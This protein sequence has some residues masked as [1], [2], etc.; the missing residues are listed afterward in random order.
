MSLVDRLYIIMFISNWFVSWSFSFLICEIL[1]AV[2]CKKVQTRRCPFICNPQ[3]YLSRLLFILIVMNKQCSIT[4]F[5]FLCLFLRLAPAFVCC[6]FVECISGFIQKMLFWKYW[7]D[8]KHLLSTWV[9]YRWIITPLSLFL[10]TFVFRI[11]EYSLFA[12]IMG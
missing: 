7:L 9:K 4:S 3:E 12:F 2:M 1:G 11:R 8:V 10:Y 5:S 6:L